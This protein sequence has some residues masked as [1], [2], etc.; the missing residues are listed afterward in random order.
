LSIVLLFPAPLLASSSDDKPS[1]SPEPGAWQGERSAEAGDFLPF[2]V[3]ARSDA[4][5]ALV[6][7]RSGYESIEGPSVR[8]LTEVNLWHHLTLQGGVS[9]TQL[10]GTQAHAGVRIQILDQARFGLDLAVGTTYLGAGY[11]GK[12]TFEIFLAASRQIGRLGLFLNMVYGQ[13]LDPSQRN[14]EVRTALLYRVTRAHPFYLGLDGRIGFDLDHGR[15][16]ND[17][18]VPDLDYRVTAGPTASYSFKWFSAFAQAGASAFRYK[19]ERS[20]AGFV[21]TGGVAATIH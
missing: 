6:I 19:Y 20:E 13:E 18:G 9:Y 4:Q 21:A 5:H 17:D 10:R 2:T 11:E 12:P 14:G 16:A 8:S 3:S 15:E 7:V 1:A